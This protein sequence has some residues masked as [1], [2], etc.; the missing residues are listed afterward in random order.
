[1]ILCMCQFLAAIAYRVLG[2]NNKHKRFWKR[3]THTDKEILLVH[4]ILIIAKREGKE[5]FNIKRVILQ[6]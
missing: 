2:A 4:S 1:M 6:K 3:K 5:K